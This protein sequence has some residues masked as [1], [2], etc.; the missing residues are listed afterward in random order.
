MLVLVLVRLLVGGKRGGSGDADQDLAAGV[1]HA[2][3]I[4]SGERRWSVAT[5]RAEVEKAVSVI[6]LLF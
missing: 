2:F 5:L 6:D 3:A 4:L 1:L